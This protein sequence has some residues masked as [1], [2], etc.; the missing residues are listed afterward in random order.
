MY[1]VGEFRTGQYNR[2]ITGAVDRYI[3]GYTNIDLE[4]TG[5]YI[6]IYICNA[7][8]LIGNI[9]HLKNNIR[10][11]IIYPAEQYKKASHQSRGRIH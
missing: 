7:M 3:R 2:S 9:Y 6:D 5:N 10:K 1:E 8:Y 11:K 4:N